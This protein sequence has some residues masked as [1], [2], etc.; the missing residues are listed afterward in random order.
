[1][2]ES[3]FDPLGLRRVA[4]VFTTAAAQ[5][6]VGRLVE[7]DDGRLRG[8]IAQVR[9]AAPATTFAAALSGQLGLWRRIDLD[10][11]D[12][13]VDGRGLDRVSIVADDVRVIETLPE[14]VGAKR[15]DVSVTV[16]PS[17][18]AAW[19]DHVASDHGVEI[20]GDQLVARLKGFGSWGLVELDPWSDGR[21]VGVD[22][23]RGRV[24]GRTVNL[25]ERLHR[26]YETELEWL[27]ERTSITAVRVADG[28][29]AIDGTIDRYAVEVDVAQLMADLSAQQAGAVI[30]VL[31]GD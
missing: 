17:H 3:W 27:P 21:R 30:S 19:I 6:L 7:I 23:A 28:A 29:I 13:S 10:I 22:V 24:R 12:A 9:E 1:M 11:A 2:S 25:P 20:A 14:R 15:L 16:G 18:V 4:D 31:L 8:R 26:R 5:T